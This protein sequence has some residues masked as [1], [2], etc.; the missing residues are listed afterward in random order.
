VWCGRGQM[1]RSAY[2]LRASL[3]GLIGLLGL[4]TFASAAEGRSIEG[5][6]RKFECG[7]NCYLTIT[8]KSRKEHT[9]LC[10]ARSCEP[11]NREV[12]MPA[13]HKG[14][15]VLVTVGRG[16]Q[17]GGSGTAMRRVLALTGTTILHSG[18]WP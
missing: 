13:R 5:R 17:L 11:W 6:I 10:T 9:G 3:L 7:D 18:L 14:R 4:T 2:R 16:T 1:P 8:D 15:R 12:S